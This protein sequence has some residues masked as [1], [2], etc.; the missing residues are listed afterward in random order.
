MQAGKYKQR[1]T[2]EQ[3]TITQDDYGDTLET[4]ST[5]KAVWSNIKPLRGTEYW[6]S[7]QVNSE[8]TGVIEIRYLSTVDPTMR[9]K[10]GTRIFE[11]DSLFH[12]EENKKETHLLVKEVL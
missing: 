8:V 10:Y 7:K 4:W 1:I 12:P 2:I 6:Q 3:L 5:F 9:V 11:I